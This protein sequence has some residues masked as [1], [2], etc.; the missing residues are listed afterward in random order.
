MLV[1]TW[2]QA[3][4]FLQ[5]RPHRNQPQDLHVGHHEIKKITQKRITS[6]RVNGPRDGKKSL[7]AVIQTWGLISRI[8]KELKIYQ[9]KKKRKTLPT[10]T[11]AKKM[12]CFQS[13]RH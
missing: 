8:L 9:K 10:N 11:L 13:K 12:D 4:A 3:I 1:K 2:V 5:V 7:P 6:D